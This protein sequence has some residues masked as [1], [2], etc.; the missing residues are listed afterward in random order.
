MHTALH[1]VLVKEKL[2]GRWLITVNLQQ[3][4]ALS[5]TDFTVRV[6]M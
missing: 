6:S 4:C 2:G 3:V 1:M 5:A